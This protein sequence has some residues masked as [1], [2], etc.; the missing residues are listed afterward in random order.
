MVRTSF[1]RILYFRITAH[2]AACHTLSKVLLMNE[3]MVQFAD[4]GD[5]FH[6][7]F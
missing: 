4:V 7:E 5:T 2:K 6:I 1:A 3:N